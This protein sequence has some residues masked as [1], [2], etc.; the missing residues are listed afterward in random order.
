MVHRSI[1]SSVIFA[2][3]VF[4]DSDMGLVFSSILNSLPW[5]LHPLQRFLYGVLYSLYQTSDPYVPLPTGSLYVY[6]PQGP[7]MQCVQY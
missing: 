1:Y 6:T 5:G 7:Q 3:L 4:N 2:F